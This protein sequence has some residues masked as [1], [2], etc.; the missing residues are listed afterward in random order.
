V[1]TAIIESLINVF[2][3]VNIGFY[4]ALILIFFGLLTTL[5]MVLRYFFL[6]A[7]LKPVISVL[8]SAEDYHAFTIKFEAI[9]G[10][11]S[12]IEGIKH[13][14]REF[15]ETLIPPLDAIDE[16]GYRIYRNTRRPSEYFSLSTS[17]HYQVRSIIA[18]STFVAIGL[19]FT[20]LGLVAALTEAGRAFGQQ[21]AALMEQAL[22]RL[23]AVAGTKFWAS[24]GGLFSSIFV[25]AFLLGVNSRIRRD[26]HL[27]CNLL[28]TRLLFVTNEKLL[29]DIVSQSQRQTQR[30]E[31]MSDEISI[32]IGDSIKNAIAAL[33]PMLSE[34]LG[35]TMEPVTEELRTVTKN[36]S[37]DNQGAL[38]GMAEEFAR[39]VSGASE[40]SFNQVNNQLER[41]I[42][43][44]EVTS[45]KLSLSGNDLTS[46]LSAAI[47]NVNTTMQSLS[48]EMASTARN[49]SDLL[50]QNTQDASAELQDVI[51]KLAEQQGSGTAQLTELTQSLGDVSRSAAASMQAMMEKSGET[52]ANVIQH[53][54]RHTADSVHES[55]T[56]IG[57]IIKDSMKAATGSALEDFVGHFKEMN[58]MLSD[59]A[60]NVS[61]GLL[62]WQQDT[63]VIG[64]TL[65]GVAT[66]LNNYISH[67]QKLNTEIELTER[68]ISSSAKAV[69]DASSPLMVVSDSFGKS[70][71]KLDVLLRSTYE[72][73]SD[74]NKVFRETSVSLQ[75]SVAALETSWQKHGQYL[76]GADEQLESA[77]RQISDNMS[78]ALQRIGDYTK[79]LDMELSKSIENLAA[80]AMELKDL[81]EEISDVKGH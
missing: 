66:Q 57:D 34:S 12:K 35:K 69:R 39:K 4:L 79:E 64:R 11:I 71:N 55:M 59:A 22:G 10:E 5:I 68:A 78:N 31:S 32:A 48:A 8:K 2:S 63:Q 1:I 74:S 21:D 80:F 18:P 28:E 60:A 67:V 27:I 14:W 62:S 56:G 46:G 51:R 61:S 33:P 40:E 50:R 58:S 29:T 36:L 75:Q 52:L 65:Q 53:S 13:P 76:K 42:A 54:V 49:S 23:L 26:L 47:D 20:F 81:V 37:A 41:L 70:A 38:K 3:I 43:S 9:N 77:F 24:V 25:G 15:C 30:L 45:S 16:P 19:L 7:S 17:H 44:L 72:M 6:R 73:T